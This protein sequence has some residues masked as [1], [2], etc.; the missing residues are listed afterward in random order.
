MVPEGEETWSGGLTADSAVRKGEGRTASDCAVYEFPGSGIRYRERAF[1]VS[2][3]GA[4]GR[5]LYGGD[6]LPERTDHQL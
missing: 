2:F 6:C 4:F 5:Q 1:V 3:A